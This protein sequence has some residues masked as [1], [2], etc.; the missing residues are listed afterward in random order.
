M[1]ADLVKLQTE[2][3]G[4]RGELALSMLGGGWLERVAPS[5]VKT[6]AVLTLP[7]FLASERSLLR[8]NGFLQRRGYIAESWGLGRNLGPRGKDWS[9]HLDTMERHLGERLQ[10]LADATSAPVSL[11]G[12]SLGGIY[13]RDLASRLEPWVDRVIMLGSP[14]FHPYR[15]DRHNQLVGGLSRWLNRHSTSELAGRTG[16][17]HVDADQP[18]LPFVAII[19]PID[20]IVAERSCRIPGYITAQAGPGSPRENLRVLSTH[21]GMSVSPWVWLAVADRLAE[22]RSGW[23]TFNPAGYF[24]GP[25]RL[26][27]DAVYPPVGQPSKPGLRRFVEASQ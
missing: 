20:G 2:L 16:L 27:R 24:P 21:I 22:A 3:L 8:L 5:A 13:A 7:G 17:L 9:R 1:L 11:V 19:S 25:L 15:I 18:R 14:T 23:R 10:A 12:Q 26:L 6:R 4:A